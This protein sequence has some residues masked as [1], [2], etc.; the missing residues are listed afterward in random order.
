M[1][2]IAWGAWLFNPQIDFTRPAYAVLYTIAP[3]W[4]WG[5]MIL[6]L[7]VAQVIAIWQEDRQWRSRVALAQSGVWF[8]IA[9]ALGLYNIYSTALVSYFWIA[10]FHLVIYIRQAAIS[11]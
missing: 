1:G 6:A 11:K 4:A 7:G 5:G 9:L 10:T 8:V 2:N 3:Q